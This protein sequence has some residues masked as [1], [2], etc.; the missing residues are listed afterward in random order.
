MVQAPFQHG[1][2]HAGWVANS[3]AIYSG[4]ETLDDVVHG[5]VRWTACQ[6]PLA[7]LHRLHYQLAHRSSLARPRRTVQQEHPFLETPQ[8]CLVL[9]RVELYVVVLVF[10]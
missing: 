6:H 1:L 2:Y 4:P 8:H 3:D 7:S 10:V 9:L 5:Y